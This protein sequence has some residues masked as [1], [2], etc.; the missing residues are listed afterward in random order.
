MKLKAV[1]GVESPVSVPVCLGSGGPPA[2]ALAQ[3]SL[4][5]IIAASHCKAGALALH[6]RLESSE[7]HNEARIEADLDPVIKSQITVLYIN[8]L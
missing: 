3:C 2:P 1:S 8:D 6:D 5:L 4:S 7:V